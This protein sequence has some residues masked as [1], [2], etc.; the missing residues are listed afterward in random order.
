MMVE[1]I[2]MSHWM[3]VCLTFRNP[4]SEL[5]LATINYVKIYLPLYTTYNIYDWVGAGKNIWPPRNFAIKFWQ[6]E[7]DQMAVWC[8]SSCPPSILQSGTVILRIF[9]ADK[10]NSRIQ[11]VLL[12]INDLQWWGYRDLKAETQDDLSEQPHLWLV[13]G[14]GITFW[15]PPKDLIMHLVLT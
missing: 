8:S 15:H 9:I 3:S 5:G 12:L 10:N 7:M 13:K 11:Q 14:F 1:E 6:G 2:H 4:S